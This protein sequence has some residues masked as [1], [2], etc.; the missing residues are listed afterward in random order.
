[1]HVARGC[2]R[3]LLLVK[4]TYAEYQIDTGTIVSNGDRIIK[5]MHLRRSFMKACYRTLPDS[6]V[7]ETLTINAR[8]TFSSWLYL[9]FSYVIPG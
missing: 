7:T 4:R 5:G 6:K 2:D 1:M 8:E 3:K 9:R